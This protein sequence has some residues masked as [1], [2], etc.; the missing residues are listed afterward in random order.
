MNY[1]VFDLEWNQCADESATLLSPVV[2]TGEII[3]IGAVKLDDDFQKVDEL[4][5]FIKPKYYT[6]L[7]NRIVSLTGIRQKELDEKGLPFPQAYE[8][9]R[10]WCG[11][12]FSY[13]TWSTSD[14]PVLLDN[15]ILHGID[16]S[17]LPDTYDIQRMF[18]REIMRIDRRLS[19]DEALRILSETGDTAHD[20]LNDARNTV[21]V[22]N[23]LDLAE[24]AG[25]Y[26]SRPYAE[27][28]LK[29]VY[30]SPREALED[31]ALRTYPCPICGE[32]MVCSDWLPMG[33]SE[34]MCMGSC[35]EGDEFLLTMELSRTAPDRFHPRRILYEMSDDLWEVY[36]DAKEARQAALHT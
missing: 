4:R 27:M 29:Q 32:A 25:E 24:F 17:D 3:E 22:C 15:M 33:H 23:H 36:S 16:V 19:L 7:H 2:L 30:S 1:I 5:L 31:V 18:S 8:R 6:K 13:M 14:L 9:F 35:S 28:P 26:V 12:E 11:E 34:H 21:L 10:Q 20:A